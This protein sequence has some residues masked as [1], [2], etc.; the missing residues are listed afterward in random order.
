MVAAAGA[1]NSAAQQIAAQMN[2]AGMAGMARQNSNQG[3]HP[4]ATP[5]Q[6]PMVGQN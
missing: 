6:N 4:Q 1:Q 5:Q 3:G 2:L